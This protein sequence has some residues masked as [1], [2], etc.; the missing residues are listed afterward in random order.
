MTPATLPHGDR[1]RTYGY[2]RGL[3]FWLG[4]LVLVP[5]ALIFLGSLLI[6]G[7]ILAIGWLLGMLLLPLFSHR[8]NRAPK[9][10]TSIELDP[11]EYRH[12]DPPDEGA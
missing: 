6:A 9:S 3:P 11:S 7:A 10:Q 2:R 1:P 12:I 8:R 4:V 5:L